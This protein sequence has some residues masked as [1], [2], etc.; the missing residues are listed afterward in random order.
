MAVFNI[1]P[2]SDNRQNEQKQSFEYR[3]RKDIGWHE[4]TRFEKHWRH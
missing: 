4:E 1:F 3:L 2:P